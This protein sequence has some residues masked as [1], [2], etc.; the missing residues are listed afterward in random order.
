VLV[1]PPAPNPAWDAMVAD[2]ATSS[3]PYR[4]FNIGCERPVHLL[5]FIELLEQRLGR[6]AE[7]VMLPMQP[8]DVAETY[9]D[10]SALRELTGYT[11]RTGIADGVAQ[12]VDWYLDYYGAESSRS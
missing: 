3:A 7:K 10:V 11:P 5:E 9:A 4:I 12:F 6:K 2:P 1:K 8:G